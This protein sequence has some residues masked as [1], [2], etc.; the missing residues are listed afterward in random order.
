MENIVGEVGV[1]VGER[2]A[3]I[4]AFV[5][6]RFHEFLELRHNGVVTALAVDGFPK[7]VMDFFSPV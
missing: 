5:A 6:A 7:A 3:H 4:I 2:P 1:V